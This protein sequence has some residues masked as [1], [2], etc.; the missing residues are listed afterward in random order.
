MEKKNFNAFT[1]L[2]PL[3]KNAIQLCGQEFVGSLTA[4]GIYAKDDEFW[5]EVNRKLNIPDDAYEQSKI[6]DKENKKQALEE[7]RAREKAEMERLLSNKKEL[8]SKNRRDWTIVVFDLLEKDK[9][10]N[11]FVAECTKSSCSKLTTLL[12]MTSEEAYGRACN[13]VDENE[14]QLQQYKSFIEHYQVLKPLYLMI[15]YL[16]GRDEYNPYLGNSPKK[17]CIENFIGIGFYNGFDYNI[18]EHLE[19]EELIEHS[20]TRNSLIL[21]KKGMQVARDML[22]TINIDGVERLLEQKNYHED[23]INYKSE[24]E[25]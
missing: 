21:F 18:I 19:K 20:S 17:R 12:S 4:N 24:D 5:I 14:K 9:Y 16:S 15:I 7:E 6:R 22:K 8:Y 3:K 23:Y 10:G 2:N 25:M 11:K 13:L 1:K